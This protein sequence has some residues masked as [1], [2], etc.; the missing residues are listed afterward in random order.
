[1]SISV[2]FTVATL[3]PTWFPLPPDDFLAATSARMTSGRPGSEQKGPWY[4]AKS[5]RT[6]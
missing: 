6:S 5:W 2:K 4:R 3:L 1:M